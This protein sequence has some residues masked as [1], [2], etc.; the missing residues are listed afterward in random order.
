MFSTQNTELQEIGRQLDA[1]IYPRIKNGGFVIPNESASHT[2]TFKKENSDVTQRQRRSKTRPWTR[3][4]GWQG[5][6]S[7]S[8]SAS[9][10]PSVVC[11]GLKAEYVRQLE[12]VNEAY[13][14]TQVWHHQSGLLLLSE[15]Y[16]MPNLR[17]KALFLTCIPFMQTK[18]VRS[19][20][21]WDGSNWIGP[22]HTNFPDGS[23]CAFEPTDG[24]W[25]AGGSIIKLLDFYTLWAFRHLHLQT[26]GRWPGNQSVRH[27]YERIL[28]LREDEYC[29]CEMSNKLY[30]QCC[31]ERD[32]ERDILADAVNF[33]INHAGGIRKPPEAILKFLHEREDPHQ[34]FN[35]LNL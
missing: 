23:V 25:V 11:S 2:E 3:A 9:R 17:Q 26:Y 10:A 4:S 24:T 18:V 30:G 16:L 35:L 1:N 7:R 19:W 22:R 15:S 8:W 6:P 28:E 20:G 21:F 31:K 33:T 29:G 13:P 12:A 5:P 27:P 34:I 32:L 14:N